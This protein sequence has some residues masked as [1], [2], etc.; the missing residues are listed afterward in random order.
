[1]P[2][3]Y[4]S[5]TPGGGY[6]VT[7]DAA[8]AGIYAAGNVAG[9]AIG[10]AIGGVLGAA[11][12][13]A[14]QVN[15]RRQQHAA[16]A[17]EQAGER[18]EW[19]LVYELTKRY[20][21]H[22]PNDRNAWDAMARAACFLPDLPAA[23]RLRVASLVEKRGAERWA[24]TMLRGF[25]YRD[26]K[27]MANLL[28]EANLLVAETDPVARATGFRLRAEALLWLGDLSQALADANAAVQLAPK[29]S[30]YEARADVLWASGDLGGA[31]TDYSRAS[32]LRPK[33]ADV[34]EKRACVYEAL[35]N[36]EL[37]QADRRSA[38]L[39]RGGGVDREQLEREAQSS[40]LGGV[41][42][43][44]VSQVVYRKANLDVLVD[45]A[46]VA[47]LLAGSTASLDLPPGPHTIQF[48]NQL[49]KSETF[50]VLVQPGVYT[51]MKCGLVAGWLTNKV[52]LRGPGGTPLSSSDN[53][54]PFMA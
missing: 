38:R 43:T 19:A 39:L 29:A 23:E 22:Y 21:K 37:A 32:L 30:T 34:L 10:S 35:G 17:V 25:V 13:V 12:G 50:Q 48:T 52:T 53:G 9:A 54:K 33:S 41:I 14:G 28:G 16:A 40:G 36:G 3:Y 5:K 1:V 46:K 49:M 24:A 44:R 27:D 8:E 6:W 26:A 7:E 51:D 2:N 42:L 31:T 47:Q 20:L 11:A 18:E 15:Y 4:V 45:G